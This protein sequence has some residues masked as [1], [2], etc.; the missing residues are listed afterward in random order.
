MPKII[1]TCIFMK[2]NVY[3]CKFKFIKAKQQN[4]N[5]WLP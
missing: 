3:F 2:I 4:N 1:E 5:V